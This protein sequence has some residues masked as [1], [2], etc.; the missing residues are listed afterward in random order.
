MGLVIK[1]IIPVTGNVITEEMI[2]YMR[3]Y[4]SP[5]TELRSVQIKVGPPSIEC[6]YAA[7]LCTSPEDRHRHLERPG[8]LQ[9]RL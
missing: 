5:D 2:A 6:E 4:L 1:N 3:K 9:D 8:Q 7:R